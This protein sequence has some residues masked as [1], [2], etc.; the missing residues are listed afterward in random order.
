M[1]GLY[2]NN[3]QLKDNDLKFRYIEACGGGDSEGLLVLESVFD[4]NSNIIKMQIITNE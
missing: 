4:I 1:I 2:V 3:K